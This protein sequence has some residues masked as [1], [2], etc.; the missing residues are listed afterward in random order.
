MLDWDDLRTFL[1]IA[2]HGTLS[3][4]ARALGVQQ[5]TMGRRLDAM[6]QRAGAALLRKTSSGYVLTEVGEAVLANVERIEAETQAIDRMIAGK[7]P[8]L[9]GTVRLTA[10]ESLVAEVLSPVIAAFRMEHPDVQVEVVAATRSLNLTKR[11][12]D[13]A[14]R[15]APFTQPDV[16]ARKV[17]E[18]ASA[19]YAARSYLDRF[20]V[21]DWVRGA[22]G[23]SVIQTEADLLHTPEMRWFRQQ[24]P[25]ARVALATNSR[26]IHRAA[27]C[28]GMGIA[29]LARYLGDGV[30]GLV[31]LEPGIRPEPV[32]D[33]WLGIHADMRHT[34]RIRAFTDALADGLKR[35]AGRLRPGA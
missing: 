10:V 5:P 13:V 20:G 33:L 22:E 23:H 7:D 3:G 18:N 28:D 8:R 32:R 15:M 16:L 1:T 4:A 35:A 30:P 19:L 21:P 26:L 34:P 11:E 25:N 9:E 12:A 29:C 27:A 31:R 24:T 2:R 17:G 6:E 14:V